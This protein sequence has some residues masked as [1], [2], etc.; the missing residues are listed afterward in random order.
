MNGTPPSTPGS[1]SI[2]GTPRQPATLKKRRPTSPLAQVDGSSH[3]GGQGGGGPGP[4]PLRKEMADRELK[5]SDE[6]AVERRRPS[7]LKRLI[8]YEVPRKVRCVRSS[9][10]A[11]LTTLSQT[12]HTSIG[13]QS[14][15]RSL[16]KGAKADISQQNANDFSRL[17]GSLPLLHASGRIPTR[18]R[19]LHSTRY[20]FDRRH[21]AFRF[22]EI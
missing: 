3:H 14:V 4:S 22:E 15:C 17:R 13:G 8:R 18:Q 2:N 21:A 10:F 1:S 6:T 7:M 20:R 12:L 11:Q 16:E 19:T 5:E 9:I